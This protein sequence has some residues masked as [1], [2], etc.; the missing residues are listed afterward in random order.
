MAGVTIGTVRRWAARGK[1]KAHLKPREVWHV[2]GIPYESKGSRW[3][4]FLKE[5]VHALLQDPKYRKR[6]AAFV[7]GQSMEA[8]ARR[9]MKEWEKTNRQLEVNEKVRRRLPPAP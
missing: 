8:Q 2:D 3:L 1:L 7:Y 5:D 6:H 9:E 4:L